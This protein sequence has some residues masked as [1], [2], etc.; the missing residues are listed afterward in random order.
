MSDDNYKVDKLQIQE[1]LQIVAL[2]KFKAV[3]DN[4]EKSPIAFL[5]QHYEFTKI[6]EAKKNVE[7][8][9]VM[10]VCWG[11]I[12]GLAGIKTIVDSFMAEDISKMVTNVYSDLS[13][14]EIY[15]AFELERHGVYEIRTDHFQLFSSEYVSTILK[16]YKSWKLENLKTHLISAPSRVEEKTITLEE[17]NEI[18]TNAL[19]SR[20]D[21]FLESGEISIPCTHIFDEM[22]T[23][24]LFKEDMDYKKLFS[25][26]GKQVESEL[27]KERAVTSF[28][29]NRL[30][31]A[32]DSLKNPNNERILARAKQLV[33]KEQFEYFKECNIHIKDVL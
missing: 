29:K 7:F 2:E 6:R 28:E 30:K 14:E 17:Q 26:S 25:L 11:K 15:K 31:E 20:F 4:T 16:K 24:R 3:E 8:N 5:K 33:L 18:M 21:E 22:Y 19:I 1:N 12:C 27:K 10:S 13:I 32:I 9:H 23:R